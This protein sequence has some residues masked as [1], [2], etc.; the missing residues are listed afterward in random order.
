MPVYPFL[1]W[2]AKQIHEY[3]STFCS[4]RFSVKSRLRTCFAL[5][6]GVILGSKKCLLLT[7]PWRPL[8]AVAS[9]PQIISQCLRHS[10]V[11][12]PARH[13]VNINI[14]RPPSTSQPDLFMLHQTVRSDLEY[15][16]SIICHSRKSTQLH[17]RFISCQ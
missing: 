10:P 7:K 2:I 13:A 4:W 8:V 3:L 9:Y 5:M 17:L 15:N 12:Y 1:T 11:S 6:L 14:S 16:R